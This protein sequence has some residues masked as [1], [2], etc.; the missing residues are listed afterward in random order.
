[1]NPTDNPTK[2]KARWE[3][4]SRLLATV[5]NEDLVKACI[6][7]VETDN[8][9]Q[10][11]LEARDELEVQAQHFVLIRVHK[12]FRY[13]ERSAKPSLPLSPED[14]QMPVTVNAKIHT[15]NQLVH[16]DPGVLFDIIFPW[17]GFDI[18]YKSQIIK[19]LNSSARFQGNGLLKVTHWLRLI[20]GIGRGVA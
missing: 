12:G 3:T 20:S 10:I 9:L 8:S 7:P 14:L 18:A 13:D 11:R 4:T 5:V 15:R 6:V 2:V 1:M 17:L 16:T 19:E